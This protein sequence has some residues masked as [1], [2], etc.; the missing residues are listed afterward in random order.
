MLDARVGRA[1]HQD[2][3]A[4]ALVGVVRVE[5]TPDDVHIIVGLTILTQ[6]DAMVLS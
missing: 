1:L 2:R 3:A 6:N 4:D 5:R